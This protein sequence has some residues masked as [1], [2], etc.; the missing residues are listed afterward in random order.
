VEHI[1]ELAEFRK[2]SKA[3]QYGSY[4]NVTERNEQL[5]YARECEGEVVLVGLNIAEQPW[6]FSGNYAGRDYEIELA[7]FEAKVLR[8]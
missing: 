7:P 5:L 2:T 8:I 6:T 1:A 4:K 3:L